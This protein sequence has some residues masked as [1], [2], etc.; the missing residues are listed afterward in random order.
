MGLPLLKLT[1]RE[2]GSSSPAL[3]FCAPGS[4]FCKNGFF[5]SPR[6]YLRTKSVKYQCIFLKCQRRE[7][8]WHEEHKENKTKPW[9]ANEESL[10]ISFLLTPLPHGSLTNPASLGMATTCY[11]EYVCACIHTHPC[12]VYICTCIHTTWTCMYLCTL[13][14]TSSEHVWCE[15]PE[16]RH[17]ENLPKVY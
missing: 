5:P 1:H 17:W 3:W 4:S 11:T 13:R 10:A 15:P 16:R 6:S 12:W 2:E 8:N 9:K 7:Y 14:H